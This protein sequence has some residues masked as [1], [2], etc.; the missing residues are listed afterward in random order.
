[1]SDVSDIPR[2]CDFGW[3]GPGLAYRKCCDMSEVY[4][5]CV[6]LL[7]GFDWDRDWFCVVLSCV[8]LGRREGIP[9]D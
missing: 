2:F 9:E 8:L 6:G 7:W 4:P 3:L 5:V 1:M